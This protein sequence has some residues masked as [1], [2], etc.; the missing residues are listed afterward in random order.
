MGIFDFLKIK[1]IDI[2]MF[3]SLQFQKEILAFVLWKFNE[4]MIIMQLK[5]N[6]KA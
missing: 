2:E 6:F 3:N 5:K 1:G 4:T